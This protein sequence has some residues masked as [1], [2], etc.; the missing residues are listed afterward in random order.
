MVRAT[1]RMPVV[2]AGGKTEF[3]DCEFEEFFA[4][5]GDAAMSADFAWAHVGVGKDGGVIAEA[6]RSGGRG[7]R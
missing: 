5:L 6:V 1:L 3:G 2:G 4:F 7:R